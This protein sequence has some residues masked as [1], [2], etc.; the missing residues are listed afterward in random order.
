[1]QKKKGGR[2]RERGGGRKG[3]RARYSTHVT[4]RE[5]KH[6]SRRSKVTL[7]L[8]RLGSG[9]GRRWVHIHEGLGA[10]DVAEWDLAQAF[11]LDVA[12]AV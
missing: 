7:T 4:T 11:Q 10:A 1:M 5:A 12:D 8:V 6:S 2:E 9:R 3:A